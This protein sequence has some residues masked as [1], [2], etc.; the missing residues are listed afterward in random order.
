MPRDTEK[1]KRENNIVDIIGQQIQ[2]TKK[3][4]EYAGICP[5]H[6]DKHASLMVN[7]KKQVFGC[8]ACGERGDVIDFL[9]KRGMDF[10]DACDLLEGKD[11]TGDFKPVRNQSRKVD[12]GPDWEFIPTPPYQPK[13]FNHYKNGEP[14][15]VWAYHNT[16]GVPNGYACRFDYPNGEKDV[17]P[18]VFAQKGDR[19]EWRWKGFPI[20]RPLYNLHLL[21]ANPKAAVLVVEGEK[22]ADAAQAE[23][24]P[25]KTVVVTWMGGAGGVAKADWSVLIGRN[26]ILLPDHDTEQKYG[27]KHPKAGQVKPWEEQPGNAAMLEIAKLIE[28]IAR[29]V[30]W[31]VVPDEYPHKWDV[32]DSEWKP[33]ELRTF[34]LDNM[35]DVPKPIRAAEE[36]PEQKPEPKAEPDPVEDLPIPP[37]D[38][39]PQQAPTTLE[40]EHYR[41]LG[42]DSNED[43]RLEYYFFSHGAKKIVK[44]TA[45]GMSKPNLMQIAP[46]NYWEDRFP[47]AKAKIDLDAAQQYLIGHSQDVGPFSPNSIRGRGAWMEGDRMVIHTGKR[48]LIDGEAVPIRSYRSPYVYEINEELGF[49][50]GE[51]LKGTEAAKLLYEVK[52]LNWEREIDAYLLAGWCV[53][54]PFCGVMNWRPH[55]WVTGPA[56]SGKSWAMENIVRRMLGATALP[57]QG[58]STE[59]GIRGTLKFDALPVLYDE[60][61][62]DGYADK[63]RVQGIL[64]LARAASYSDGGSIAKGTQSGNS[65]TYITRSCFA[66]SSIGIQLNQQS[67]RSRFSILTLKKF[68]ADQAGDKFG[69]FWRRW[70]ETF[71]DEYVRNLQARTAAL[72]P[73][74][75][76]NAKT[77]AKAASHE[78]QS[79]RTGDQVGAMLAGVYSLTSSN[80]ITYEKAVEWVR[81]R[82]WTEEKGMELT[83]D[84]LQLFNILSGHHVH[85]EG[86]FRQLERPIGELVVSA[87]NRLRDWKIAQD[88]A[89]QRLRRLGI[90]VKDE[91]VYISNSS[92]SIRKILANTAWTNN[93]GTILLRLEGAEKVSA[94]TYYPGLKSRGVQLPIDL[95]TDGYDVTEILEP[96]K[97]QQGGNWPTQNGPHQVSAFDADPD[98][99]V[100]F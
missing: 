97:L 54:A 28:D 76:E 32:A 48:L 30:R 62:V 36:Q 47:A 77:F 61:D 29:L 11:V 88:I 57:V 5:F 98:D 72:I 83:K 51:K 90:L 94:R 56:G 45:S 52:W 1:L 9:Q 55:I 46:I 87:A 3:G 17:I 58:K 66:F 40:N 85:V 65:R 33:H 99:D 24:D 39:P 59:A 74:I 43:A 6:D 23:L 49:G 78:I 67:D 89:E 42:Y 79:Q 37:V 91:V 81:Q 69:E 84:E 21:T 75:L 19:Q 20:P 15:G 82:D 18:F 26:V 80:L 73:V 70:D 38:L 100:P 10:H 96:Q 8:F 13:S 31:I 95:F 68:E 71:T 4:S 7:E 44:L 93:Y 60:A 92:P 22:T 35:G 53:I 34:L 64:A 2:L 27:D 16:D 86:D 14:N 63:E 41:I 12:K 25:S 50:F